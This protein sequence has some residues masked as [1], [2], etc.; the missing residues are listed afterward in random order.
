MASGSRAPIPNPNAVTEALTELERQRAADATAI[1]GLKASFG[2]AGAGDSSG[3][4][5]L[6][7]IIVALA[8]VRLGSREESSTTY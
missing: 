2:V 1:Q 6:R 8:G 5:L 7:G 3:Q 4:Q